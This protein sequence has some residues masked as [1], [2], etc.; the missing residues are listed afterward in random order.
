MKFDV[1]SGSQSNTDKTSEDQNRRIVSQIKVDQLTRSERKS[2]AIII[3]PDG[4]LVVRAP[5]HATDEHI[6]DFIERKRGWIEQKQA[7]M[8]QRPPSFNP[9]KFVAG[10]T[11]LYLGQRCT[12]DI[13]GKA[14]PLLDFKEN[15]FIL[16]RKAKPQAKELLTA[17]YKKQA[18][19][20]FTERL[21]VYARRHNLAYKRL[22]LSSA[23]TRWGSYSSSGTLSLTW[24]L[25]MAPLPVIDYVVVHELAHTKE[26]NHAKRFWN[27][28][29]SIMPDYQ[30][31]RKWLK[32]NGHLLEL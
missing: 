24:R 8:R 17:W 26:K 19:Q 5:H 27:L 29:A 32:E 2:I 25:V 12:L 20:V 11:L 15:R 28:V 7:E 23:R 3:K 22:H 21:Q 18:R 13:S 9:P 14:V 31:H 30:Q 4:K 6:L 10:E 1:L 16:A